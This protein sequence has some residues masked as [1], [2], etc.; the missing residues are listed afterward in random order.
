[1]QLRHTAR[2][3]LRAVFVG[4]L[5]AVCVDLPQQ[6]LDA[7]VVELVTPAAVLIQLAY[8]AHQEVGNLQRETP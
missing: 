7:A 8:L 3:H 1:M 5:P 4:F 6:V 2:P